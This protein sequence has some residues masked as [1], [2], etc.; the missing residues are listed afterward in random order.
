ML[1]AALSVGQS[2]DKAESCFLLYDEK[3]GRTTGDPSDACSTRATPASTFKIPH[4][5]AALDARVVSGPDETFPYDGSEY[6]LERWKRDHDLKSAMRDSVVWYFQRIAERLGVERESAYL[7]AFEYGNQDASGP[8]TSFWLGDSLQISPEEQLAF[9]R[10]FFE[11]RLP[12]RE[13][14]ARTVLEILKQP[15]GRIVN[16]LGEHPLAAPWPSGA[17]VYAKTGRGADHERPVSWLVGRIVRGDREWTFVSCV[18]GDEEPLAAIRLAA[19]RLGE[20]E[21]L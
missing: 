17:A 3:D 20:L 10:R 15:E 19:K 6:D 14:A 12:V 5:L 11:S 16:A 8:L 18:I 2:A 9:L 21:I 1:A 13:D 4:A 7:K